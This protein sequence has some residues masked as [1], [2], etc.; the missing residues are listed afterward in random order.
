MYIYDKAI[1]CVCFYSLTLI[2]SRPI[3]VEL[4]QVHSLVPFLFTYINVISSEISKL[5]TT[6]VF[7]WIKKKVECCICL[8]NNILK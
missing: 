2:K 8:I 5:I 6:H 3:Y 4:C 7:G 1:P